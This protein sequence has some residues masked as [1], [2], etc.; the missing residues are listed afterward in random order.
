LRIL[1]WHI[2]RGR[3]LVGGSFRDYWAFAVDFARVGVEMVEESRRRCVEMRRFS[4]GTYDIGSGRQFHERYAWRRST[5]AVI[6]ALPEW[7]PEQV[8]AV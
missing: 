3:K 7:Q 1:F 8:V 5:D 4:S 6:V 2:E